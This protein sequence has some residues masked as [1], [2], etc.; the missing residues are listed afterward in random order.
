MNH[1][2]FALGLGIGTQ[3]R[4]GQWLEV[5]F[6]EPHLRPSMAAFL[7]LLK[8]AGYQGGNA[9]ILLNAE[10]RQQ[11][12]GHGHSYSLFAK[13]TRPVVLCVLATDAT[14]TSVPEAYL[15]LHLLSH[16]LTRPNTV[17]LTDLFKIL[18]NVAWTNRGPVDPEEL[19]EMRRHCRAVGDNLHVDSV[20]KFPRMVDYI[21]PSGVR[22]A[23]GARVRLGAYLGTGT[24]VMHEGFINFNAGCEGPNMIE[25]RISA[26]VFVGAH[27]DIGGG[28]STMGTLSGGNSTRISVGKSTLLGANSGL[29][30]P[31][32]DECIVEAG[33][34]L[35]AASKVR[36]LDSNGKPQGHAK[37]I[38][39]AGRHALLF[40][41]NSQDGA[42]EC[43][44]NKRAVALNTSLHAHN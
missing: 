36:L 43:L 17:N 28:A 25:G 3:N 42:I 8:T 19:G 18:P 10:Q 20:D 26:G 12:P 24:T 6:P 30:I 4:S 35:T 39:L 32:G 21:V 14:I 31:L 27:S 5:Y 22:I 16:R 1:D 9:A 41:R 7:P 11:L 34:Y 37:A 44:P 40:R 2:I 38:E 29:G 33:L 23:D 15:K 13:A